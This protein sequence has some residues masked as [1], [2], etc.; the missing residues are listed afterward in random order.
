MIIFTRS[1]LSASQALSLAHSCL[2][3]L[4]P[5]LNFLSFVF[6]PIPMFIHP[7]SFL[8]ILEI[9]IW[10]MERVIHKVLQPEDVLY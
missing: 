3:E 6:H 1:D 5:P 9:R 10:I 7:L 4:L 8:W 2:L